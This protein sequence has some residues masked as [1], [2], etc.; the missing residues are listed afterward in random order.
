MFRFGRYDGDFMIGK[1][2]DMSCRSNARN[3]I[4]DDDDMFHFELLEVEFIQ[5]LMF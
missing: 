1:F 3:A 2:S 4:P 5:N